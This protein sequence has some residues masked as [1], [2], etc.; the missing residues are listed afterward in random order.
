MW[1]VFERIVVL[2]PL[3]G[4]YLADL[5]TD[6]DHRGDETVKLRERFTFRRFHHEGAGNGKAQGRC[7]EAVV[8][9]TFGHIFCRDAAGVLQGAQVQDAFMR[10]VTVGTR[11]QG[12]VVVL[13]ARADVVGAEDGDFGC[14]LQAF[15]A[16]HA[17]VHP[18]DGQ[19]RCIS[20]RC[21]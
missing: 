16:H 1:R 8:H 20:K 2:R 7:V 14:L 21:G 10:H 17:A 5:F 19:H 3:P 13:Q 9:Q 11:V 15:G 12:G 6:G 18:A 4:F